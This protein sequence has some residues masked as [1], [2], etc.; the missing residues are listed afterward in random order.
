MATPRRPPRRSPPRRC[1]R[2]RVARKGWRQGWRLVLP[3]FVCGKRAGQAAWKRRA[4]AAS[5][6]LAEAGQSGRHSAR[7]RAGGQRQRVERAEWAGW[8]ER[9]ERPR[10]RPRA[11]SGAA[12]ATHWRGR[13]PAAAPAARSPPPRAWPRAQRGAAPRRRRSAGPGAGVAAAGVGRLAPARAGARRGAPG[14]A[15]PSSPPGPACVR[16]RRRA[17]PPHAPAALQRQRDPLA[18]TAARPPRRASPGPETA[19]PGPASPTAAC[20]PR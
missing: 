11:V 10:R 1:D 20:A 4:P 3:P 5:P 7:P 16:A 12:R 13:R 2:S 14:V 19:L 17:A 6:L 18:L 9:R 15:R 8:K